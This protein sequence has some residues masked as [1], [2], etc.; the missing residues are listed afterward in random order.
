MDDL[1]LVRKFIREK[2]NE[3][4][5]MLAAG[6]AANIEEYRHA[7][8]RV[9]GMALVERYILDLEDARKAADQAEM[10]SGVPVIRR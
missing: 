3:T 8:G 4:A 9:L 10:S 1:D 7:T 6:G 5:D 2:M